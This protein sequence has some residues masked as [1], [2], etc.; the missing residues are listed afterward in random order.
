MDQLVTIVS[1]LIGGGTETTTATLCWAIVY[2]LRYPD[3]QE[4]LQKEIDDV[5]GQRL[6]TKKDLPAMPYVEACIHE[7][8]RISDIVPLGKD[9]LELNG[10]LCH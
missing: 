5:I 8:Q 4:R 3:V 1:D 9:C 10:I 2:L 7:I 6:P